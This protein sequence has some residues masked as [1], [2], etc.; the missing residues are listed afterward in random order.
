MVLFG[1]ALPTLNW[2]T[3]L[4]ALYESSPGHVMLTVQT[5]SWSGVYSRVMSLIVASP[6]GG[7]VVLNGPLTTSVVP[8]G[9]VKVIVALAHTYTS[10]VYGALSNRLGSGCHESDVSVLTPMIGLM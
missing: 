3:W 4:T 9:F 1:N 2:S 10:S 5:P 6:T 8:S 7:N